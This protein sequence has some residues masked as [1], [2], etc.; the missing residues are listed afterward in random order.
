MDEH[1]EKVGLLRRSEI[2][3]SL[4][5]CLASGK[6]GKNRIEI[7]LVSNMDLQFPA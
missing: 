1:E 2:F 6:T 7:K 5:E 3:S 4:K